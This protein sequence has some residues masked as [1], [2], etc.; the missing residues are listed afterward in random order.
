MPHASG[1][2]VARNISRS[3]GDVDVLD[4]FSLTVPPAS[5]IGIVG[6]NGIGK[7]TL[8]RILAR[9]AASRSSIGEPRTET[10][11]DCGESPS[12]LGAPHG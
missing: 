1:V 7:S 4:G 5:R 8:L 9:P 11:D 12:I 2:L 10:P 3:Y 6:P